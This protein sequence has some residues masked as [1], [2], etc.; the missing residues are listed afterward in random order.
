MDDSLA[1]ETVAYRTLVGHVGVA[2]Q[3]AH[4]NSLE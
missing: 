1:M 4:I 3:C 2:W